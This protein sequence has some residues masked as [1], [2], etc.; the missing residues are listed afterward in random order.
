MGKNSQDRGSAPGRRRSL[1]RCAWASVLAASLVLGP[2]LAPAPGPAGVPSAAADALD[3]EPRPSAEPDATTQVATP[4]ATAPATSSQGAAPPG[5]ASSAATTSAPMPSATAS[6]TTAPGGAERGTPGPGGGAGGADGRD[7]ASRGDASRGDGGDGA[8]GSTDVRDDDLNDDDRDDPAPVVLWLAP[9]AELEASARTVLEH[10]WSLEAA[11]ERPVS[12]V[13]PREDAA[14]VARIAVTELG[15]RLASQQLRGRLLLENPNPEPMTVTANAPRRAAAA[16]QPAAACGYRPADGLEATP[17]AAAGSLRLVLPPGTTRV[18]YDCPAPQEADAPDGGIDVGISFSRGEHPLDAADAGSDADRPDGTVRAGAAYAWEV[19]ELRRAVALAA[20]PAGAAAPGDAEAAREAGLETWTVRS[21]GLPGTVHRRLAALPAQVPA[22]ACSATGVSAT[23]LQTGATASADVR[24]CRWAAPRV[25]IEAEG[26]FIRDHQWSLTGTEGAPRFDVD[27]QGAVTAVHELTATATGHRDLAF[28]LGGTVSFSNPN[29]FAVQRLDAGPAPRFAGRDCRY[30]RLAD[31]DAAA[32]GIQL[33]VPAGGT[34][35]AAFRCD[36]SSGVAPGDYRGHELSASAGWERGA[37][38]AAE[39]AAVAFTVRRAIDATVTLTEDGTGS[40]VIGTA[41]V[42][43]S[44]RTFR[45]P[46]RLQGVPGRCT[47]F[48]FGAALRERAGADADNTTR[49]RASVCVLDGLS[50]AASYDAGFSRD[51]QWSAERREDAARHEVIGTT[52]AAAGATVTARTTGHIDSGWRVA[53]TVSIANPN[54]HRAVEVDVR[55]SVR[56]PGALCQVAGTPG[57]GVVAVP[58]AQIVDGV[59]VPGRV[60]VQTECVF[61][62]R[63]LAERHYAGRDATAV[64]R[65]TAPDGGTRRAVVAQPLAFRALAVTD[66]VVEV[67]GPGSGPGAPVIGTATVGE[68]PAVFRTVGSLAGTPGR[69][70][71]H[72]TTATVR[73]AAGQDA[74]NTASSATTVCAQAALQ[75]RQEAE[76]TFDRELLWRLESAVDRPRV[77][78]GEGGR[79]DVGFTVKATPDGSVDGNHFVRGTVRLA[80]PN[81]YDA[82]ALLAT[83]DD[84]SAG[85]GMVCAYLGADADPSAPGFQVRVPRAPGAAS[86]LDAAEAAAGQG[87]GAGGATGAAGPAGVGA[88]AGFV[89]GRAE[90]GFECAGRPAG[91]GEGTPRAVGATWPGGAAL[92]QAVS[93][94]S[95]ENLRH[96]SVRIVDDQVSRSDDPAVLGTAVW[97]AAG[98]PTVFSYTLPFTGRAGVCITRTATALLEGPGLSASSTAEVCVRR[99]LEATASASASLQRGHQWILEALRHPQGSTPLADGGAVLRTLVRAVPHGTRDTGHVVDG[100]VRVGNPNFFEGAAATVTV[101]TVLNVGG[102]GV[103]TVRGQDADPAATG[104]QVLVPAGTGTTPGQVRVDYACSFAGQPS[105][106]GAASTSLSWDSGRTVAEAPVVFAPRSETDRTVRVF[107]RAGSHGT[108]LLGTAEWNAQGTPATFEST[109]EIARTGPSAAEGAGESDGEGGA[110]RC[111]TAE[112]LQWIGA[113]GGPPAAGEG[114]P[115]GSQGSRA[116]VGDDRSVRQEA[117]VCSGAGLTASLEAAAGLHRSYQWSVRRGVEA[118]DLGSAAVAHVVEAMPGGY[119]DSDWT[120]T[121]AVAVAHPGGGEPVTAVL[122]SATGPGGAECAVEGDARL[123]LAPGASGQLRY[124]CA[125]AA[126]PGAEGGTAAVVQWDGGAVELRVPVRFAVRTSSDA[127][128]E[129]YD[130]KGVPGGEPRL[131]GLARWNADGT[132]RRF[133]FAVAVPAGDGQCAAGAGTA[134][135]HVVGGPGPALDPAGLGLET[136]APSAPRPGDPAASNED[137]DCGAPDAETAGAAGIP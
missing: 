79:A 40:A 14:A 3:A 89:P 30:V 45:H 29:D 21:S 98:E 122:T 104:H 74:D 26:S 115:G 50:V 44:P 39:P 66:A 108:T 87:P 62:G 73:E 76:A 32:P 12:E 64:V 17:G 38:V 91:G 35:R 58:A 111:F 136:R 2:A 60:A 15:P 112:S 53:G 131:L 133:A 105:P 95:P 113:A 129:V 6:S 82:G 11:P 67:V 25:D 97:N 124:R 114:A 63:G 126:D 118:G 4:R 84:P 85:P 65:W 22:A 83:L 10:E 127:T 43:D 34:V 86:A 72:S 27:G 106:V 109:T 107:Q 54:L 93:T 119:T 9:T 70:V 28:R 116:G 100:T 47:D 78:L 7:D 24:V 69:C 42:A 128:V 101:E 121:G 99:P 59:V 81:A 134:F 92:A 103:C 52:P 90:V 68:S 75:L 56:L 61:G 57:R 132:A 8:T 55:Q 71:R 102:D 46:L 5:A 110:G 18:D 130:D 51:H 41:A 135:I 48:E 77:V 19:R 1:P 49:G 33:D 137:P 117:V 36:V 88:A 80:N 31:A 125:Y 96:Q 23:L 13:G 123:E 120:V 37:P 94:S 16:G 20:H